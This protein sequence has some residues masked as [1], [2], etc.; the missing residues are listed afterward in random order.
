MSLASTPFCF[1]VLMSVLALSL[2]AARASLALGAC[3]SAPRTTRSVS[4]VPLTSPTPRA[5]MVGRPLSVATVAAGA[6]PAA[7]PP[8]RAQPARVRAATAAT[9][10][11]VRAGRAR[12]M[13]SLRGAGSDAVLDDTGGAAVPLSA[14]IG[15]RAATGLA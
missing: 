14:P 10:A 11:A 15:R 8:L 1:K 5:A 7:L 13:V 3:V 9:A 12:S 4:G 6:A 2:L